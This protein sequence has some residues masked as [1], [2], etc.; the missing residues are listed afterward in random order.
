[1]I[2]RFD[3][4]GIFRDKTRMTGKSNE[5]IITTTCSFDCGGRCLLKVHVTD[6]RITRIG[7]DNQPGPGLK[8][9]IR[10]LSQKDV[11]YSPERLTRPLKRI[12]ERG[13]GQFKPISWEAALETV[14]CEIKRIKDT[15]GGNSIFLMDYSGNEAAL[16]GTGI[17]ARRFFNLNGGCSVIGGNTSMEAALFASR[18]TLGTAFTGNSRDNLRHSKLIILWGWDPLI[19]RFGPDTVSYLALAQKAGA[20][21]I[22]VDPRFNASAKALAE[23]WI[24][25]KPGTDTAMLVAMAQ[26]MIEEDLYDHRF[27]ET[28]T[29]GFES[30][31]EYVLGNQDGVPKTPQWA[32]NIC[33][34]QAEEIRMLARD[35]ATIKPA[36]LWASWAPGRSAVGEQYHR[37][38]ITLAAMT[39]NIGIQGGHVAGGAGRMELGA[40]ATSFDVPEK[41]NP[42]I[43]MSEIYDALLTGK[44]GGYPADIKLVYIVGCNLLNQF[45]NI[46]K[47]VGALKVPEFIVVHELFMTPTARYADVILPVTHFLEEEDIGSPW[48][49]GPYNIYMNRVLDPLPETH[50]DLAI[51]DL[52]A[53]RMGV[54][55]YNPKS[56]RGYLQEMVANTPRLTDDNVKH[57]EAHRMK[58]DQP[59]VAFRSQI[60]D[61]QNHPFAT[62]SGKIEIYSQV[63]ADMNDAGL[64]PIP[65]YIEPWEGPDDLL[66]KKYPLQLVSPHAK[67][68]VN[69]QFDNIPGLKDKSD[70]KIWLNPGDARH[71]KIFDG[72][73]VIVY[74]AR[75]KLRSIARVTDRIMPGVV[76]LSGGA[77]YR[78][79]A[80]GI[81]DGGCV[82]VLTKDECSPGGAFTCNSCLVEIK[83]DF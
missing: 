36:A 43:H 35:Y 31:K 52:L 61:P 39:G 56:V 25:V 2:N 49:G 45:L 65:Q 17:A 33:G 8:A 77:W 53:N 20:K 83:K 23:K 82:N 12:G 34:A 80:E 74:N 78:P 38:A 67:G 30:F 79:D 62:P 19:S 57:Q 72:D 42:K 9:C 1:M 28:Y 68:R 59:W 22:C 81:D 71:R 13:S 47:G 27:I 37:A 40:L 58:L 5:K 63:L 75:G 14:A 54:A 15:Y 32:E 7:T 4:L 64:P 3:F 69:S 66:V 73:R 60:E 44:S 26:V 16:H 41:P 6:G 10:G 21:I 46:N 29:E 70:D 11:V 51:F 18:T 48:T 50:S 76:S 55:D 24:P